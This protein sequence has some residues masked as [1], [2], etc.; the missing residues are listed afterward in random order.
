MASRHLL[1]VLLAVGSA[2]AYSS[3]PTA[4]P[5]VVQTATSI[6]PGSTSTPSATPTPSYSISTSSSCNF[7]GCGSS[8]C[9]PSTTSLL[10]YVCDNTCLNSSTFTYHTTTYPL[11]VTVTLPCNGRFAKREDEDLEKRFTCVPGP[12][13][14]STTRMACS[15][16]HQFPTLTTQTVVV[17]STVYT[18]TCGQNTSSSSSP[19]TPTVT[20][21]TK[22]SSSSTSYPTAGCWWMCWNSAGSYTTIPYSGPTPTATPTGYIRCL[23]VCS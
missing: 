22:T 18:S 12:T 19:P 3:Y 6:I 1:A 16:C 15:D 21:S 23:Q 2:S 13:I 11:P 20:S 10:E 14:T 4:T 7:L 8:S 9:I 17:G 5:T